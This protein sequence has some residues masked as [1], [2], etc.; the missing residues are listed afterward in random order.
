MTALTRCSTFRAVTYLPVQIG[1]STAIMSAV[2]SWSTLLWASSGKAW[3]RRLASHWLA[4]LP[5]LRQPP[6]WI[7]RTLYAASSNVG[8]PAV[9]GRPPARGSPPSRA[10]LRLPRA[11]SRASAS[12]TVLNPPRPSFRARPRTISLWIQRRA[13]DGETS[14]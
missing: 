9:W 7:A 13:P 2:V 10:S 1:N 11:S 6:L 14:R 3:S 12:E 4:V 5:P 8:T